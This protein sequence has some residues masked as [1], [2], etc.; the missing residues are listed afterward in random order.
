MR[1]RTRGGKSPS[2]APGEYSRGDAGRY[3]RRLR[4][5]RGK[6]FA[7]RAALGVLV[8]GLIGCGAAVALWLARVDARLNNV[9]VVTVELKQAL[10]ERSAPSDPYYVLLMGTDGRPGETSYR[11]DSIILT[12]VDPQQKQVT[13]LS[14]PRDSKVV[15]KG[16]TVKI[17]AVH[18]Y[19]GAAGMVEIVSDLCGVPISHYAEVNFD[20]LAGITDALGGVTVYVDQD[21]SDPYHFDDVTELSEGTH[22][23]NGA[24]ALFYT[25]CRYFPDGDYTRMRHQRTFVKAMI[26]Q[27]MATYDPVKLAALVDACADMLITDLSVGDIVALAPEMVGIDGEAGIHMS[28]APSEPKDIDG[29]S[30]V[31][32]DEDALGEMMELIDAGEDPAPLNAGGY[33]ATE[34]EQQGEEDVQEVIYE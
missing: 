16:F 34:L 20:G 27:I 33:G 24:E 14:I 11:A 18:A 15:W 23:L 6:A 19:D 26:S 31:I 3:H 4:Q 21:M 28:F 8:L 22:T 7:V 17:N 9:D 2:H 10:V 13:L 5:R 25:R 30:Y 32:L 12:R 29:V 1:K